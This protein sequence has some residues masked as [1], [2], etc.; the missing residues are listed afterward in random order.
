MLKLLNFTLNSQNVLQKKQVHNKTLQIFYKNQVVEQK[1]VL[2]CSCC[3]WLSH[4]SF[5]VFSDA[6]RSWVS[7]TTWSTRWSRV[8]FLL[9]I[10]PVVKGWV[11]RMG[12][13]FPEFFGGGCFVD[14]GPLIY[15]EVFDFQQFWGFYFDILSVLFACFEDLKLR[16]ISSPADLP[17]FCRLLEPPEVNVGPWVFSILGQAVR[18]CSNTRMS[19]WKLGSMVSKWVISPTYKWDILGL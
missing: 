3:L 18:P 17:I 4:N 11:S 10:F 12:F 14:V 13:G 8:D 9:A 6:R 7:E 16:I 15:E 5:M 2:F 1:N 19:R